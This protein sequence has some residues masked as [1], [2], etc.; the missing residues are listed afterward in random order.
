MLITLKEMMEIAE[1][2]EFAVG[3]FDAS[4]LEAVEA[5][6][7]AAEETGLPVILQFAQCHEPLIP[8]TTIG[9]VLFLR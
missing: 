4:G 5:E 7:S 8:L 3:A 6:I 1:K 2:R 9:M